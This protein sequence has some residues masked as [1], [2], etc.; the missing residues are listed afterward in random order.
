MSVKYPDYGN[1]IA[2]LACSILNYYGITPPNFTLPQADILLRKEYKNVV[3]L[4]LDGMGIDILEKHLSENGFFRKNLICEYSSTFPPTTVA[5]TTA[6]FSGLYPNQSAWLGWTGY[7]DEIDKTVIYFWNI[8][9]DTGE[10]VEGINAAETF[11]PYENICDRISTT[12]TKAHYLAPFREPHPENFKAFCNE[13]EHLCNDDGKKYIYAYWDEP[14]HTMHDNGIDGSVIRDILKE[15]ENCTEEMISRLED[16]LVII[17]ADHGHINNNNKVITDYPDITECLVRKP[18]MEPRALNLFIK[19]G[20]KE[21]FENAFNKHFGDSFL[22]MPKSKV[23]DMNLLGVGKNH[24]RLDRM[25]GDYLAIAV[26]NVTIC[27]EEGGMKGGHAGMTKEE[28]T[29]PLIAA[30]KD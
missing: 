12:K 21:Q 16:T 29:I 3:L 18:S 17:T 24:E 4:L 1:C 8:D 28:M 2:N 10:P 5:A 25:L 11:V 26:S 23:L 19:D 9:T 14:D 13:I 22:L 15:I 6:V 7:F 20:M 30:S 27:N